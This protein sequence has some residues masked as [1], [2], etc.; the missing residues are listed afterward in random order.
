MMAEQNR[1]DWAKWVIGW[2]VGFLLASLPQMWLYST[3]FAILETKTNRNTEDIQA[4]QASGSNPVQVMV[5]DM[6][7][8]KEG[9]IK[10]QSQLD[11]HIAKTI[12]DLQAE[13]KR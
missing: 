2:L 4:I 1:N 12:V 5:S 8:I 6:K 3:R 9:I 7:W 13:P 11:L 10:M